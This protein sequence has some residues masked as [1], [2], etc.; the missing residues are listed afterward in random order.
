MQRGSE[1]QIRYTDDPA[2]KTPQCRLS[3]K[4]GIEN[5]AIAR[6]SGDTD[7]H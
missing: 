6:M 5:G 3:G 7:V 4:K 1:E 2:V